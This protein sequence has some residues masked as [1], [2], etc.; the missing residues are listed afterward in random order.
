MHKVGEP[1][2]AAQEN[3]FVEIGTGGCCQI[4]IKHA[5]IAGRKPRTQPP[6]FCFIRSKK[7]V[8]IGGCQALAAYIKQAAQNLITFHWNM[9]HDRVM[10]PLNL[11]TDKQKM[12]FV[13]LF[14]I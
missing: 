1:A 13:F 4:C 6:A 12:F 9:S 7:F 5:G 8:E 10:K 14:N 2:L 11:E 3:H